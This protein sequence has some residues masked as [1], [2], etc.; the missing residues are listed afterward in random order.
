MSP[1]AD[2]EEDAARRNYK[3]P[4]S[5]NHP[6]PTI[7]RY[8]EHREE[9]E[10]RTEQAEEAQRTEEDDSR[11]RRAF[12][13]VKKIVKNEDKEDPRGSPYPTANRHTHASDLPPADHD[14]TLPQ[15]RTDENGPDYENDH[16]DK[17][18]KHKLTATEQVAGSSDPKE[19]RKAMK[20]TKRTDGGRV[21]TDP[22]TH[23]PLVIRDST[24][25][26]LKRAPENDTAPGLKGKTGTGLSVDSKSSSELDRERQGLQDD[27]AGMQ[28][29]FPPPSFE[30]TRAELART[31]QLALVVGLGII[32]VLATLVVLFILVLSSRT[33]TPPNISNSQNSHKSGSFFPLAFAIIL[34]AS[35]GTAVIYQIQGW[36]GKKIESVWDDE[37]WDAARAQEM[38][39]NNEPGRLPES[40]AWMNSFLSSVWPLINP[41]LFASVID[42]LEDVMQASLPKVIRMV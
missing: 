22:I 26:D 31:Y 40:V 16:E 3:A 35:L 12:S 2:F 24:T 29:M 37:V 20:H 32:T 19:K 1:S 33:P 7:Q 23:L 10:G 13:S 30:D 28:K 27:Y 6:I 8:R 9:L 36:L 42:M 14:S 11:A 15:V 18:G 34:A 38:K 41:D 39:S 4:Y 21:V 17:H 5:H 25:K